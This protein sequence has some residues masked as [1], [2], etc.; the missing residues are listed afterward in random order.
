MS[1]QTQLDIV[2]RSPKNDPLVQPMTC[3]NLNLS[4]VYNNVNSQHFIP[5]ELKPNSAVSLNSTLNFRT[6]QLTVLAF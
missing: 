4:V 6:L 5:L 3:T 2:L 1:P